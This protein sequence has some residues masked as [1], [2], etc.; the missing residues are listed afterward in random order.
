MKLMVTGH[1]IQKLALYD[2]DWVQNA[3]EVTV[4]EAVSRGCSFGMS[5]MASGVDLWFCQSCHDAHIPYGAYVPFDG[6]RET[7]DEE[8]AIKRDFYLSLAREVVSCK[9][10]VMVET[11]NFAIV[12]WDGNKGGT[13]NCFQQLLELNKNV[14]WIIPQRKKVVEVIDD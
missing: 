7:M 14:W 8:W 10:R 13:H 1:R 3:I 5:G 6:Q 12:V 9:N 2:L 11:C 4:L